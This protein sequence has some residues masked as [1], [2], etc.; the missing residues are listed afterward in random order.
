MTAQLHLI[1]DR[2]V[3]DIP[4]M[5]REL[6]S[7]IEAGDFGDVETLGVVLLGDR[8]EVFGMGARGESPMITML[9]Q[10]AIQRLAATLL[11]EDDDAE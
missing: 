4:R 8:L 7:N 6:A 3:A 9:F 10:A 2:N 11:E 1:Q 5:L